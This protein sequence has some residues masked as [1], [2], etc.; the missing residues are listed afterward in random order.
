MTIVQAVTGTKLAEEG[1]LVTR[2]NSIEDAASISVLCLDKDRHRHRKQARRRRQHPVLRV[3]QGRR[4]PNG[5]A[6]I[7]I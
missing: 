7:E 2:L 6:R 5:D 4:S 3:R 1:V